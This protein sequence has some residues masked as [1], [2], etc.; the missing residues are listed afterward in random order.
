V[1][2]LL[3]ALPPERHPTVP[4]PHH[5]HPTAERSPMT[6]PPSRFDVDEA[7]AEHGSALL[8]FAVNALGDR[9]QA[10]DCVQE[11]F[12]RAWRARDRFDPTRA[13][14]RTWLFA[15]ERRVVIDV[16]R[17]RQRTPHLVTPDDAPDAAS[18]DPDPLDRLG[19]VE[20]LARLSDEHRAAVVAV[21]L[22]G[23]TYRDVSE[24]T[25]VPVATLRTR[26]HYALRALRT[27]LDE[28]GTTDD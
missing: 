15:I 20:G 4:P 16:L 28:G 12:L 8:G 18:H 2:A 10:E 25:G 17:A 26:V 1:T 22:R 11:T 9:G 19:L 24:S 13:S 23:R 6:A 27:H 7:F 3:T 14:A 21:H 5:P